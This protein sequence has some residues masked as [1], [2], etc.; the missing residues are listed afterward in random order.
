[1]TLTTS[2]EMRKIAAA[3][4][5]RRE[6]AYGYNSPFLPEVF[7]EHMGPESRRS[8][9][10]A[11]QRVCWLC[12]GRDCLFAASASVPV[13]KVQRQIGERAHAEA[14]VGLVDD[15]VGRVVGRGVTPFH[16]RHN[17]TG[18]RC[19]YSVVTCSCP[20]FSRARAMS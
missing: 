3:V 17:H 2:G 20:A 8:A 11:S 16:N 18:C 6:S 7:D 9:S 5:D 1:M 14:Q 4:V 10:G 15:E 12:G 19:A 13:Q